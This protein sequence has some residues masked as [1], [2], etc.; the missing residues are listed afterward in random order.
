[1][2]AQEG[3]MLAARWLALHP[4]LPFVIITGDPRPFTLPCAHPGMLQFLLKP[5]SIKEFFEI[6]ATLLR[7][8]RIIESAFLPPLSAQV[9]REAPGA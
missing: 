4:T 2:Q 6:L 7:Y 8:A 9:A 5:F 3:I 1:M